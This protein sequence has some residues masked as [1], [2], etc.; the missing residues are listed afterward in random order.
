MDKPTLVV[1]AVINTLRGS[2]RNEINT[3]VTKVSS[4]SRKG[5][6]E[7]PGGKVEAG[8]SL[9]DAIQRELVEELGTQDLF[10]PML[11]GVPT[12]EVVGKGIA[13][14]IV[15][16]GNH[17]VVVPML[18]RMYIDEVLI[19]HLQNSMWERGVEYQWVHWP[20]P[21]SDYTESFSPAFWASRELASAYGRRY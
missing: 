18:Y 17:Y 5:L 2:D 13:D 6:W 7:L 16:E 12:W 11:A 8:E 4:G 19:L 9:V 1:S 3:L 15:V 20:M 21:L 10:F 14:K